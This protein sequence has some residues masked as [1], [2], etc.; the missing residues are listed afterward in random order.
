MSNLPEIATVSSRAGVSYIVIATP[1]FP[2]GAWW[3][4]LDSMNGRVVSYGFVNGIGGCMRRAIQAGK[5]AGRYRIKKYAAQKSI[6][7]L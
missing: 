5:K 3:Q 4:L 6:D 1:E 2:D 7:S